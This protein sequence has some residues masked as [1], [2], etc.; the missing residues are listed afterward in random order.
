[1]E[2][3]GFA[4]SFCFL[5]QYVWRFALRF[6]RSL[7]GDLLPIIHWLWRGVLVMICN[8]TERTRNKLRTSFTQSMF[9]AGA[10]PHFQKGATICLKDHV[11]M[12]LLFILSILI[13]YVLE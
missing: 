11:I 2:F 8:E 9:H 12:T 10:H 7:P 5:V 6:V 3:N 4:F 13:S 1:M